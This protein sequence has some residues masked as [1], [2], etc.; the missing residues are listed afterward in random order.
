VLRRAVRGRVLVLVLVAV[1]YLGVGTDGGDADAARR[2]RR[3]PASTVVPEPPGPAGFDAAAI[4][5]VKT[6]ALK[7][8]LRVGAVVGKPV[9]L[10]PSK[11]TVIVQCTVALDDQ[12]IAY[13]AQRDPAGPIVARATFPVLSRR[14]MEAAAGS[15]SGGTGAP[16]CP[17]ER[18]QVLPPASEIRCTVGTR[19]VIVRVADANGALVARAG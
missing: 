2:R 11:D 5:A 6:A 3:A 12:R 7:D 14:E 9:C 16:R 10:Q 18:L 4:S 1:G 15:V 13:L 19:T 17:V 8:G